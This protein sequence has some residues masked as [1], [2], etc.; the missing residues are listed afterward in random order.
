MDKIEVTPSVI[1]VQT[2]KNPPCRSAT[3]FPSPAPFMWMIGTANPNNENAMMTMYPHLR[4]GRTRVAYNQME[5][6]GKM[7]RFE[8]PPFSK[9]YIMSPEMWTETKNIERSDEMRNE[10]FSFML[11]HFTF[12]ALFCLLISPEFWSVGYH[13]TF[14]Q[15]KAICSYARPKYYCWVRNT[16][17]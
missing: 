11:V 5:S 4:S 1:V 12:P 8:V 9:P 10:I 7:M 13:Y 16:T 6:I 2:K 17:A 15:E 3:C 14:I